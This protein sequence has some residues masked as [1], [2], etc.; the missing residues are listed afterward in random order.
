MSL[1][2]RARRRSVVGR[3]FEGCCVQD[4]WEFM[5][6]NV[7]TVAVL[8]WFKKDS[9]ACEVPVAVCLVSDVFNHEFSSKGLETSSQ[10]M[11]IWQLVD[12]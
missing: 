1:F 3:R 12:L 5:N 10:A 9:D 4:A 7:P 11:S 6:L 8:D 2:R